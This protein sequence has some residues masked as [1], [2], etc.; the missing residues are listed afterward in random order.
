MGTFLSVEVFHSDEGKTREVIE[1]TFNE[2]RRIEKLLS[3]FREDSQVYKVN[4][5]AHLKPQVIGEELFCLIT[6][7]LE[8]LK[9]R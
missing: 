1:M 5:L 2:V 7:C 9:N 8:F 6:D 3:R 4:N